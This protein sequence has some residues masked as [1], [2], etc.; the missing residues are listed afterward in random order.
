M[1]LPY[2]LTIPILREMSAYTSVHSS[3]LYNNKKRRNNPKSHQ[4]V[5]DTSLVTH[6]REYY[7]VTK[8]N[9]LL[10]FAITQM[11]LMDLRLSERSHT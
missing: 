4:Q 9:D 6:T 1:N 10:S 8:S 5:T 2:D 7:T 3:I 11:S